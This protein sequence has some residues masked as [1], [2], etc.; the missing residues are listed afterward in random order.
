VKQR[1]VK[2]LKL[3]VP[4]LIAGLLI[5]L[6]LRRVD[7]VKLKDAFLH[8]NL[9]WVAAGLSA[10]LAAI[11]A[12]AARYR[13]LMGFAKCP[14]R[15]STFLS[16]TV[17][18][19]LITNIFPFRLGEV[20]RP[21]LIAKESGNRFPRLLAGVGL[22]RLMDLLSLGAAFGL[23]L[24][25]SPDLLSDRTDNLDDNPMNRLFQHLA[26]WSGH[27]VLLGI[28]FTLAVAALLL[29]PTL[30]LRWRGRI[31]A[32]QARGGW[33]GRLAD[34]VLHI[35]ESLAVLNRPLAALEMA[36]WS[37]LITIGITTGAILLVLAT[38]IKLTLAGGLLLTVAVSLGYGIPVPGGIG[39]VQFAAYLC[40]YTVLEE[41]ETR[42]Q[43]AGW[44]L[45]A[46][47][48]LPTIIWGGFLVW[49]K[50]LKL[51]EIVDAAKATKEA[52]KPADAKLITM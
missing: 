47:F 30:L 35:L 32:I 51:M 16:G 9:W 25:L 33:V 23:F 44:V 13:R 42:S 31:D 8:V 48:V 15:F 22:E 40:L 1:L 17:I 7:F 41:D 6:M 11:V 18:G 34:N 29:L 3:T 52:E 43:A 4:P 46:A 49:F 12:R 28:G 10:E 2:I 26:D 14:G 27:T 45:W 24:V 38:G 20:A 19:Y 5:W 21:W 39:G 50:G 36:G 37:V